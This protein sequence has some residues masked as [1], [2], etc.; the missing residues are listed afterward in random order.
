VMSITGNGEGGPVKP[1]ASV[2]DFGGG[3]QLTIAVLSALYRRAVTGEGGELHVSLLDSMMSMLMNYSVAVMD[4]DAV[5]APMGSGHP[6]LVPFQAFPSSDGFIVIATGTNRL[7]RDLCRVLGRADLSE[8][9]HFRTNV[10]RVGH[11]GELVDIISAECV[12]K[13]TAE[14]LEIFEREG[15]PCAPVNTLAQAFAEE[16]L[17]AQGM[18]VEMV[19]PTYGPIHVVGSP[20]TF[21]GM[22]PPLRSGPPILGEHTTSVLLEHTDL[23]SR[24][25]ERLRADNVI[26]GS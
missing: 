10:E 3:A 7:F 11:R 8:N 5:I 24:D 1:G 18:V 25:V 16:Q 26:G 14:W 6:Q 20:Y 4:G 12:R 13:S 17:V 23:S 22:R 2:A 9:A 15:I 19:H 21:G